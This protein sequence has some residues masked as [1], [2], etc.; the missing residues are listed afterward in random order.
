[1]KKLTIF[2]AAIFVLAMLAG[3]GCSK[4]PPTNP[5]V[6]PPVTTLKFTVNGTIYEWNG[7]SADDVSQGSRIYRT[8]YNGSTWYTLS[9]YPLNSGIY[10]LLALEINATSLAATTYTLTTTTTTAWTVADHYCGLPNG[11]IFAS[12]EVGDVASIIITSIVNGYASGTF[13]ATLTNT[14]GSLT[15]TNVTDG[16][17]RNVKIVQ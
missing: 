13:T 4:N 17:F 3:F 16:Q 11:Q 1:M 14:D 7:S 10:T 12:S 9:A 15:K 6:T 8:V 5:P 2:P